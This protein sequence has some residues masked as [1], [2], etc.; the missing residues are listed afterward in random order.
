M[1]KYSPH[2][3]AHSSPPT[4]TENTHSYTHIPPTQTGSDIPLLPSEGPISRPALSTQ[5][6]G[7]RLAPVHLAPPCSRPF[8]PYHHAAWLWEAQKLDSF[9]P[10]QKAFDGD[11]PGESSPEQSKRP[12]PSQLSLGDFQK[13]PGTQ[14]RCRK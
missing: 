6:P 11:G 14:G 9:T 4:S 7:S 8:S 2:T 1:G 3:Y 13:T 5:S 10:K 12:S